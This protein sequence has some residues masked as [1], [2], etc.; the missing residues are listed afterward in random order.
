MPNTKSAIKT[1]RKDAK[2]TEQ[3]RQMKSRV[4]TFEKNFLKTIE[5]GDK[6][7]SAAALKKVYSAVDKAVKAGVLHASTAGRKKSRLSA[8]FNASIKA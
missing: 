2:R 1:V 6:D 5:S 7:A 3:N 4:R 8:R